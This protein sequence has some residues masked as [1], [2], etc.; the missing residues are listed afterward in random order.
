LCQLAA[1][2]RDLARSSFEDAI[3]L[4]E[5][6]RRAL[7]GDDFRTA[8]LGDHLRPYQELL[9]IELQDAVDEPT[10][11][12]IERVFIQLERFRAREL[13][14]RLGD[15]QDNAGTEVPRGRCASSRRGNEDP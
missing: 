15:A 4:F 8:F 9:S 13:L 12:A 5:E 2:E 10:G 11:K 7:P 6:Q 1:G 14:E 3:A